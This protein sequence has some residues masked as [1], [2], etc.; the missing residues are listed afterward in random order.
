M[1]EKPGVL[2]KVFMVFPV[3]F[4]VNDRVMASYALTVSSLSFFQFILTKLTFHSTSPVHITPSHLL[5]D[6]VEGVHFFLEG[7]TLLPQYS[8]D[9]AQVVAAG[10][11]RFS[12][13]REREKAISLAGSSLYGLVLCRKYC[14]NIIHY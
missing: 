13:P 3:A 2:T 1:N 8:L 9:L 14:W 7:V 5:M 12:F 11:Y 4:K 6:L 10:T